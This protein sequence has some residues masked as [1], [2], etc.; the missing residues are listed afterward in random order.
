MALLLL[1]EKR[2]MESVKDPQ[3]TVNPR[4][5]MRLVTHDARKPAADPPPAPRDTDEHPGDEPGYGHGV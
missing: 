1:K 4:P 2:V 5:P 3:T